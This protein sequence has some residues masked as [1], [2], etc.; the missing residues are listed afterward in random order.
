MKKSRTVYLYLAIL[1]FIGILLIFVFDGYMGRI[2][3]LEIENGRYT[4]IYDEQW[5][6]NR[7][8]LWVPSFSSEP[9]DTITFT[10]TVENKLFSSYKED[11]R[12]YMEKYPETLYAEDVIKAGAFGSDSVTWVIN[13]DEILPPSYSPDTQYTFNLIMQDGD[14]EI[15]LTITIYTGNTV[16]ITPTTEV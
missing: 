3:T 2:R 16:K 8:E 1:C 13:T 4:Q 7:P 9:G 15:E 5:M 14:E 11:F 12:A 6:E 10:Y